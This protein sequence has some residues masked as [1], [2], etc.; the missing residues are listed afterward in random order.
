MSTSNSIEIG[1]KTVGSDAPVF[2]I[3]EAGVNHGGSLERALELVDGA[4]EAGADAVK[5]QTWDVRELYVPDEMTGKPLRENS[6]ERCLTYDE[7]ERVKEYCDE[8]GIIFLSTP[9]ERKSADFLDSLDVPAFK[10]GSGELTNTPFI[11]HVADKGK[12]IIISTGMATEEMIDRAISAVKGAG[13]K[14]LVILHCVSSYPA[15]LEDLNLRYL[16]V[17]RK[18]FDSPVGL[19][20]HTESTLP[21][22]LAKALDAR[23]IEKHFTVDK[24]WA[25]TDNQFSYNVAEFEDLV[26]AV[27]EAEKALG[28][29]VKEILDSESEARDVARKRIVARNDIPA[30]EIIDDDALALKRPSG[31]IPPSEYDTVVG[32]KA[33]EKI[34]KN[35]MI[36][37]EKLEDS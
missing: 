19:S 31:G 30:G 17:L 10:I 5:F 22:V 26:E 9:D 14:D 28:D 35:E 20:D 12:P 6:R 4:K 36:R 3:A 34:P 1:G 37:S 7:F 18:K 27:R 15:E 13:Q 29:P 16:P 8:V 32:K 33:A 25:G 23:V 11:T 24:D 21:A 2:I